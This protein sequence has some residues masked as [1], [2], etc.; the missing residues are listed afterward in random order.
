MIVVTAVETHPSY[1]LMKL[2]LVHL[3]YPSWLYVEIW[4]M[5][6]SHIPL[7]TNINASNARYLEDRLAFSLR[8]AI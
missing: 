7:R 2:S 3:P 1:F 6:L 4:T 8:Q 5:F